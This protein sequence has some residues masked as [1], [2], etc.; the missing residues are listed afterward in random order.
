[1]IAL[2]ADIWAL[3]YCCSELKNDEEIGLFVLDLRPGFL[4]LLG[5]RFRNDRTLVMD[6]FQREPKSLNGASEELKN[7]EE[8]MLHAIQ[9]DPIAVSFIGDKLNYN[10]DFRERVGLPPL[11]TGF[12]LRYAPGN[13]AKGT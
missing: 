3:H 9:I 1:M 5:P 8:F 6:A 11:T 2:K 10:P 4:P 13:R 7:D 12:R